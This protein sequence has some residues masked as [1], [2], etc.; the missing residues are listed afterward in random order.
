M[1]RFINGLKYNL[2]ISYCQKDIKVSKCGTWLFVVLKTK[3]KSKFRMVISKSFILLLILSLHAIPIFG[4]DSIIIDTSHYSST[5]GEIRNFRI[6]LPAGY[7]EN[8][9]KRYPVIYFFHGWS[10]RYFGPVGDDYSNYDKGNENGGDNIANY[11]STHDV[12]VVKPDGFNPFSEKEYNLSPYNV[13]SIATTRQFPL[14]FPELVDV[15]DSRYNTIPDREHRAVTGLSMGGFMSFLV[16][17]KYPHLVSASGNFCGSPEFMVGPVKFPVEYRNQDMY[18]NYAGMN[19]RFHYGDKDNLRF[20]HQDMNRVW[21]QVMDNYECKIY[22]ARHTTCGLGE[23]L[24]F[25]MN[26]FKNPPGKPEKWDHIDI[27]PEFSVWGY[28]VSSDRFV[29]GF[30][31]LEDVDKRGF[32][33]S[34][35]EFLPD[36]EV[37]PFV[38]LTVTTPPLYEK[39]HQYLINDVER[40]SSKTSHYSIRS[41]ESGRLRLTINGNTHNIG[42][43]KINDLPNLVIESVKVENMNRA[44]TMQEVAVRIKILNKGNS[45]ADNVKA[46]LLPVKNYVIIKNDKSEFGN[47][48]VNGMV[49]SNKS[50]SFNVQ[51][52]SIEISKFRLTITDGN[53]NEW[54]DY[55]DIPLRKDQPEIR[56]FEIADG[57]TFTVAKS[58][59]FSETVFLGKGNGDGIANPGE[60]IVILVK[61]QDKYWRTDL[62]TSDKFINPGGINIRISDNWE[63]YDGIGGSAKYSIPVISS[64]CPDNHGVEFYAE[65]WVPDNKKHII[66]RGIIKTVVGGKDNTGPEVRWVHISGNN[67]LAVKVYDG[68]PV[69]SVKARLIPVNDVKGLNNV[70]LTDPKQVIE[71]ELKD[72]GK[73]GDLTVDDKVFTK[74][75]SVKTTYFYRVETEAAD[76]FGNKT[77]EKGSEVFLVHIN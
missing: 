55:F 42:I 54:I 76:L 77:I 45:K 12:I 66:K 46:K 75:L 62:F 74:R 13:D 49:E 35:R 6:F 41:D 65:Y 61:D 57:R 17:G 2:F 15:I 7:F 21:T 70:H 23:M 50:F 38:S 29:P 51:T 47:I 39:N 37:M 58:G 3:F 40:E 25:C 69:K 10:Q 68:S 56:N 16:G 63:R 8:S 22:D 24:N 67:N 44:K 64:E 53:K 73:D 72:D 5:F 43:N 11:V 32:R 71:F 30:T 1:A 31:I 4:R 48:G 52:D 14:Y 20:Y 9:Q 34:A 18:K 59:I 36:G 60:S 28:N 33:C 27:Y 26:T 19:V